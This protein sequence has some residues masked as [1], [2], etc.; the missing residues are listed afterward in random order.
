[1]AEVVVQKT[2]LVV[3]HNH[4]QLK[5]EMVVEV[6]DQLTILELPH[7]LEALTLAV[8]VEVAV[9]PLEDVLELVDQE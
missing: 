7:K 5:V 9:L 1:V 2:M 6:M 4:Y 3:P 8:V